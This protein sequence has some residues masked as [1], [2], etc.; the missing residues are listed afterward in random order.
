M[1]FAIKE[2]DN[3]QN[4]EKFELIIQKINILDK[5]RDIIQ[6]IQRPDKPKNI[7]FSNNQS[8]YIDELENNIYEDKWQSRYNIEKETITFTIGSYQFECNIND[9][10]FIGANIQFKDGR[11]IYEDSYF[12][13]NANLFMQSTISFI[14]ILSPK[15]RITINRAQHRFSISLNSY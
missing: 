4:I 12:Y 3:N 7:N 8:Y 10:I 11:K 5:T 1:E 13:F 14:S 6:I 15:L 2:K 9:Q